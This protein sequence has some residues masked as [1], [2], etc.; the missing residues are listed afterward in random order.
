MNLQIILALI[1]QILLATSS[2]SSD[3]SSQPVAKCDT[4]FFYQTLPLIAD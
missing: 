4:G 3:V 1:A 2:T